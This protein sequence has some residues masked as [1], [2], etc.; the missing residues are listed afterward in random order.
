M[1]P[2]ND[3][4]KIEVDFRKLME[5]FLK[6]NKRDLKLLDTELFDIINLIK[7]NIPE[8]KYYT[9]GFECPDISKLKNNKQKDEVYNKLLNQFEQQL[10]E[11]IYN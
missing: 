2:K 7:G 1:K 3:I 8:I 6:Y 11:W 4:S 10:K 9:Y 5:H